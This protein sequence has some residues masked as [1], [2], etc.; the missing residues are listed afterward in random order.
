MKVTNYC[1]ANIKSLRKDLM[2]KAKI[3]FNEKTI[4]LIKS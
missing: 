1:Y 3:I 2:W 4:K